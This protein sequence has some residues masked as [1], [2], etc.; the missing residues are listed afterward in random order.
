MAGADIG[1]LLSERG[2]VGSSV[3]GEMANM[4]DMRTIGYAVSLEAR[5]TAR[6]LKGI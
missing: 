2:S 4:S 1:R 5:K 3:L 6:K